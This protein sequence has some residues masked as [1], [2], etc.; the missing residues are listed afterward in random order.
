MPI[1]HMSIN[2][3]DFDAAKAFYS[4]ALAPLNYKVTMEFPGSVGFGVP[5]DKSDFFLVSSKGQ[6][7]QPVH[8]AFLGQSE[9]MVQQ[10]HT[11][12]FK[13]GEAK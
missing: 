11:A 10:F 2:V 8:T 12:S 7:V 1:A 5:G 6:K 9:E 4:A 3:A 13:G